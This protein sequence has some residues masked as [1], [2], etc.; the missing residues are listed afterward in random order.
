M[1]NIW[2]KVFSLLVAVLLALY[3]H[4]SSNTVVRTVVATIELSRVPINKVVL[5]PLNPTVLVTLRGPSFIMSRV[6]NS[7]PVF[8]VTFPPHVDERY[9]ANLSPEDLKLPAHLEVSSIEPQMIEFK[10]DELIER[11]LSVVV[12]RIGTFEEAVRAESI[13]SEPEKIIATGPRSELRERSSIETEALDLRTIHEDT[14][15]SLAFRS[16]PPLTRL[17]K[18]RVNVSLK[19]APILDERKFEGIP[20]EVRLPSGQKGA[21][22]V[23]PKTVSV[24]L[25]AAKT[26]LTQLKRSSVVAIVSLP[27]KFAPGDEAPITIE[28]PVG[29]E[30][31][32]IEPAT[33][34]IV[35][36]RKS[37]PVSKDSSARN[38]KI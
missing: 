26:A 17:S 6:P 21:Q 24:T 29:V 32:S 38:K 36:P 18:E 3:V 5:A 33:V 31:V 9:R 34:A 19:L 25:R 23:L 16:P 4:G 12:P 7:P 13:S 14:T 11:E 8:S 20:V 35:P 37:K 28:R 27:E 22:E 10:L 15:V 2:L 30:V 1:K